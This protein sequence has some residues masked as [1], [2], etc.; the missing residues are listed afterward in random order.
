MSA[1]GDVHV[2]F[3]EHLEGPFPWVTR[4]VLLCCSEVEEKTALAQVREWAETNGLTLHPNKTYV[5]NCM[6]TGQGFEFLGFRFGV[7]RH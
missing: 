1:C 2:R 3:H 7:G 6:V 5:G 4:L